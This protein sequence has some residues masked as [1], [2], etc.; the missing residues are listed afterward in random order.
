[1]SKRPTRTLR[2]LTRTAVFN[3]VRGAAYAC[4]AAAVTGLGWWIER[5]F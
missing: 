4:G 2:R 1:M 3:V 5:I